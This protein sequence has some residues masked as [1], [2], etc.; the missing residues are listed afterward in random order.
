[1]WIRKRG[2]LL[3]QC[4]DACGSAVVL[5]HVL[6]HYTSSSFL[7][8]MSWLASSET[9]HQR[10]AQYCS[11]IAEQWG[12][13][14]SFHKIVR[15][16]DHARR[17][18]KSAVCAINRH[19]RMPGYFVDLHHCAHTP[20]QF[21]ASRAQFI[22]PLQTPGQLVKVHHS[23]SYC[24]LQTY[25]GVGKFGLCGSTGSLGLTPVEVSAEDLP[26]GRFAP[27][28]PVVRRPGSFPS[29]LAL[30]SPL[31]VPG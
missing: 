31:G 10:L 17:A 29:F 2:N 11:N 13:M 1:M 24:R 23:A 14:M 3:Y 7:E 22:A 4:L 21:M 28:V 8:T 20:G 12:A 16:A 19:L 15:M 30:S 27:L 5:L 18:D 9:C 26:A 6:W 25:Q